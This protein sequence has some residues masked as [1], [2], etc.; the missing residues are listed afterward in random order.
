MD[1]GFHPFQR[2]TKKSFYEDQMG[3]NQ[4]QLA[5]HGISIGTQCGLIEDLY[6]VAHR[7]ECYTNRAHTHAWGDINH[8]S[9]RLLWNRAYVG[10]VISLNIRGRTQLSSRII[11]RCTMQNERGTNSVRISGIIM[12]IQLAAGGNGSDNCEG[13]ERSSVGDNYKLILKDL[14]SQLSSDTTTVPSRKRNINRRQ[15]LFGVG[16]IY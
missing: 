11:Q 14:C 7:E 16:D 5:G 13:S 4:E 8:E 9:N 15:Q 2:S 3:S 12:A 6:L 1:V 10:D